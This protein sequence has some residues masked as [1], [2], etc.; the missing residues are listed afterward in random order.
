VILW[1]WFVL[2]AAGLALELVG[3]LSPRDRWPALTDIVRRYVPKTMIAAAL[4][5]LAI[6]FGVNQ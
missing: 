2:L 3:V 4:A 5:W 1:P 6:H